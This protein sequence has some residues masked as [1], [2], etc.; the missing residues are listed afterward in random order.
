[1]TQAGPQMTQKR[2]ENTQKKQQQPRINAE[3]RG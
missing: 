1:M 2:A 3:A